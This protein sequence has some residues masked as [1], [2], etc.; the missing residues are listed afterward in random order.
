MTAQCRFSCQKFGLRGRYEGGRTKPNHP[1]SRYRKSDTRANCQTFNPSW[2]TSVTDDAG[3]FS[4]APPAAQ[5][6]T[7][8]LSGL[9]W[10]CQ[11]SRSRRG[12]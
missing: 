7:H 12:A 11:S 9:Q 6:P 8:R 5:A 1:A 2:A 10:A 4:S 3:Q